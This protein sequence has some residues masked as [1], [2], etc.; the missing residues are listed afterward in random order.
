MS[1]KP[2]AIKTPSKPSAASLAK[3]K[4]AKAKAVANYNKLLKDIERNKGKK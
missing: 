1:R 3:A 2:R 4:K